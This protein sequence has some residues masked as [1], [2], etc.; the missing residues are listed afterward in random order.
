MGKPFPAFPAHAQ[1]A[2]LRIWQYL[3]RGPLVGD[4]RRHVA[5]LLWWMITG[6]RF[7]TQNDIF[8]SLFYKFNL[9]SVHI[10]SALWHI[11]FWTDCFND[12]HTWIL[13][14]VGPL[15]L[16]SIC[17][18]QRKKIHHLDMGVC[19]IDTCTILY[20]FISEITYCHPI[21]STVLGESFQILCTSI[22]KQSVNM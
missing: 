11:L 14:W 9:K 3:A 7:V 8:F 5:S 10:V 21:A 18:H 1:P 12:K 2:I 6:M 13:K 15:M 19:C 20:C 16:V 4:L 22:I 17:V